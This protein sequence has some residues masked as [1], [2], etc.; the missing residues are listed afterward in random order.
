MTHITNLCN[1]ITQ[2]Q[3]YWKGFHVNQ[4]KTHMNAPRAPL[5]DNESARLNALLNENILDTE[6]E[7]D[8]DI[9]V[10]L[11]K[12]HFD[13]P[14]AL[15][16]FVDKDRQWFKSCI[17][18]DISETSRD[19]AFCAHAILEDVPLVVNDTHEDERFKDNPLVTGEPYIRFYAGVPLKSK[20]GYNLGT[21]CIVDT[22]PRDRF[23]KDD[24]TALVQYGELA[25]SLLRARQANFQIQEAHDAKSNFVAHISHELRTPLNVVVGTSQILAEKKSNL[26]A[27]TQELVKSLRTSSE[28]LLEIVNSVLDLSSLEAK[29]FSLS[30]EPFSFEMLFQEIISIMTPR[31]R[32]KRLAFNIDYADLRGTCYTGDKV[33]LKQILINLLNNAIKFTKKGAVTLK[34]GYSK[35]THTN[36]LPD[37][38]FQIIDTGMGIAEE[39]IA[40]IFKSF[41]K[42]H[43]RV[44]YEGTGLGLS[45]VKNFLNEMDG[46]IS[47]E[48]RIGFGTKFLVTLPNRIINMDSIEKSALEMLGGRSPQNQKFWETS[49]IL[50][51][52]DYQPNL[53]VMEHLLS[54]L[55]HKAT[56]VST[57]QE[58]LEAVK[59]ANYDLILMD[60]NMPDMNGIEATQALRAQAKYKD[61][62][63]VALSAHIYGTELQKFKEAGMNDHISKPV[64]RV[65]LKQKLEHYLQ[66]K[67]AA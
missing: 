5:P 30:N 54:E 34:A 45:I 62:P 56:F 3:S 12:K 23:S 67:H 1:K 32:E 36:D 2:L 15:I 27:E 66:K 21:F 13:V 61:L 46:K 29:S 40:R 60:V 17:G 20:D 10:Q 42:A 18:V 28:A 33:R 6:A 58:V 47:V 19:V 39:D 63:I 22:K 52:E 53:I 44:H 49:Q 59:K 51:A 50:V 31:A 37:I 7:K 65:Q 8:F 14:I 55:G 4:R 41:E 26:S 64:D 38:E 35:Q 48:S 57:G 9:L 11:A 16:S 25:Q 43:Q 24:V